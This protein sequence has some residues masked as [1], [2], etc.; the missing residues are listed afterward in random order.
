MKT[1]KGMC[2]CINERVG[3]HACVGVCG[4][5]CVR[6]C[7]REIVAGGPQHDC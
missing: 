3:V 7:M 6:A 5:A 1:C 2:M 4:P